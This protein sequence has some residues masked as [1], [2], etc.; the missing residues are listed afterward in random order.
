MTFVIDVINQPFSKPEL[1]AA[2]LVP[3]SFRTAVLPLVLLAIWLFGSAMH[4]LAWWVR[5][6]R[7]AVVVRGASPLEDR[8]ELDALR[9]LEGKVGIRRSIAA[10]T[11]DAPLEPGIFGIVRP[12]L[13]WPRT[14]GE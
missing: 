5:W 13:V 8:R 2:S 3:H 4:L 14:I 1:A 7:V 6:R 11:S 9:R 10:L 12:V